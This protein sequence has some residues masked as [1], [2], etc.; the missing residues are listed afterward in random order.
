MFIIR[1][2]TRVTRP[3][4]LVCNVEEFNLKDERWAGRDHWAHPLLAVG[5]AGIQSWGWRWWWCWWLQWW[6]GWPWRYDEGSGLSDTHSKEPLVPA[7][8]HLTHTQG[9][10]ERFVPGIF[11]V[12]FLR[13]KCN[14]Q[15]ILRHGKQQQTASPFGNQAHS[16]TFNFWNI[17]PRD[18]H[19]FLWGTNNCAASVE[20]KQ[21]SRKSMKSHLAATATTFV[22]NQILLEP[23]SLTH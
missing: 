9:E 14:A 11:S 6:W 23:C 17:T 3:A 13:W 12:R 4:W 20:L 2:I 22:D 8:D 21:P 1:N 7:C 10:L 16:H 19:F 15:C 5:Q 18:H